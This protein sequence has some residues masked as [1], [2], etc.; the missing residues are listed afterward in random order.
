MVGVISHV[1]LLRERIDRKICVTRRK[2][3]SVVETV[4]D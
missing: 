4:V 1:D 2:E 3:G